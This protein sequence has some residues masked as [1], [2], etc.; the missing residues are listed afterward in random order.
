GKGLVVHMVGVVK[1]VKTTCLDTRTGAAETELL[2]LMHLTKGI[3]L[4]IEKIICATNLSAHQ[5]RCVGNARSE[6]T[7][8]ASVSYAW[9]SRSGHLARQCPKSDLPS[10]PCHV[11]SRPSSFVGAVGPMSKARASASLPSETWVKRKHGVFQKD[12]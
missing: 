11:K 8:Q 10:P 7:S 12:L 3:C 6:D 2:T 4:H 1:N 5:P 9:E